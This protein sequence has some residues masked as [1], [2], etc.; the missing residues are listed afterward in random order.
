MVLAAKTES[1]VEGPS[2]ELHAMTAI[3]TPVT[4]SDIKSGLIPDED[5]QIPAGW[6]LI[7]DND[8]R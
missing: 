8:F 2:V 5:F 7:R 4:V 1:G 3:Q 6:K